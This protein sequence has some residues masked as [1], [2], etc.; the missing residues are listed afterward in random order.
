MPPLP[1]QWPGARVV[2]PNAFNTRSCDVT[3]TT[4]VLLFLTRAPRSLLLSC[5]HTPTTVRTCIRMLLSAAR[6]R[7]QCSISVS[8][9]PFRSPL[10]SARPHPITVQ[11]CRNSKFALSPPRTRFLCE[12]SNATRIL[13]IL[14]FAL[15]TSPDTLGFLWHPDRF[16]SSS[17]SWFLFLYS[18]C[19]R[20]L[21]P[22]P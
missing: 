16:L 5:S 10:H 14:L 3:K 19:V 13:L 8:C 12:T 20:V 17:T 9:S 22:L 15:T 7:F 11:G 18:N 2:S 4:A 1:W 6:V 21:C